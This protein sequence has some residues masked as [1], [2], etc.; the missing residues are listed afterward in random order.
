M[1][2]PIYKGMLKVNKKQLLSL[3]QDSVDR[4]QANS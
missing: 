1:R 4:P 2:M 3:F